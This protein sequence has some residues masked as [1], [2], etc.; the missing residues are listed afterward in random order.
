MRWVCI[1]VSVCH[2]CWCVIV[3]Y[4]HMY[5]YV[6]VVCVCVYM[7]AHIYVVSILSFLLSAVPPLFYKILCV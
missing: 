5:V 1:G 6:Y 7:C 3:M 2:V 4:I